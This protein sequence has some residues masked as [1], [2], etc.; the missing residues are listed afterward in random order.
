MLAL[1]QRITDGRRQYA[2][3]I[4]ADTEAELSSAGQLSGDSKGARTLDSS[5]LWRWSG[6][7]W[8]EIACTDFASNTTYRT[9]I[10]CTASHIAARVA[11]TYWFG[12]GQP[13]GITGTGTLYAPNIVYID[14][15]DY[16]T[17]GGVTPK[18]RIR[19]QCYTNDVAPTGNF[20][21]GL[22]PVT[23]PAT[24]GGAGVC[25]YTMGALVT[26]SGGATFT[27]PAA[28]AALNTTSADFALPANGHYVIGMV[29]TATVATSAHV[30][31]CAQLQ[32][33]NA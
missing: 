5:K 8:I 6:S 19:A 31:F 10:D 14:A 32:L 12:Q 15:A 22:Y 27:A 11:G 20:T 26:G 17:L 24:S 33:H 28:D 7:A 21:L 25:I 23:R 9:V 30:Q 1:G 29:T 2:N 3:L 4:V 13:A 18:L 16:P